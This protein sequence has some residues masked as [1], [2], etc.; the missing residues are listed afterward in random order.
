MCGGGAIKGDENGLSIANGAV[1]AN[2]SGLTTYNSGVPQITIGTNGKLTF[3]NGAVVADST[4]LKTYSGG[5]LQCNIGTDGKLIAGGGNVVVDNNGISITNGRLSI[6]NGNTVILDGTKRVLSLWCD[7][8]SV[9]VPAYGGTT[10][11]SN[12]AYWTDPGYKPMFLVYTYLTSGHIYTEM[13]GF[14]TYTMYPFLLDNSSL[15]LLNYYPHPAICTVYII[16][17]IVT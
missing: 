1:I 6:T 8:I 5:V 13:W 11:G 2:S 17:Q 10:P 3:A 12:T 16:T 14:Q 9:F 15:Q 4:G 7:P